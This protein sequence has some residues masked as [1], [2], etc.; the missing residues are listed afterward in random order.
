MQSQSPEP[1]PAA[2]VRPLRILI[3]GGTGFSGPHQ[4]RYALSRGHQVTLFNRG[5]R[6][7]I[8][9]SG[10]EGLIGDREANDYESLRGR[11]F[12]VCIDNPTAVPAW[13][14]DAAAVL[15]G[16]INHY[17][18][19]STISVYADND[20]PGADESARRAVYTGPDAMAETM[21]GLRRNM[22]CYGALKALSEDE[23]HRQFAGLTTVIR[24]GL[25]VGPGDETDRFSY[26]PLRLQRG[27]KVLVPPMHDPVRF[28]DVRDL[29][30]WTIR[31][32]E[33]R[34][35]GDFNAFGPAHELPMGEML[36]A[37]AEATGGKAQLV[38]ASQAFLDAHQV[39]PWSELPVW[40]PGRGETAGMHRR[41]NA[42][43]LQAGLSFRP[44]SQTCGDF[45]AWWATLGEERRVSLRAGLQPE[46]EAALLAELEA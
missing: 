14:R 45:L 19:I 10:V 20:Q 2:A 27:G 37:I 30:E 32:A 13:V 33:Q 21:V 8:W 42:R 23:A 11:R 46:R 39:E 41:S 43:A 38:E 29:A 34:C 35:L 4:I 7:S 36:K 17:I 40:V 22:A 28:I 3:L 24:P 12:D 26:W 9:P 1:V 44:L 16:Q 5:A 6:S 18:F 15:K 25:I 31:M